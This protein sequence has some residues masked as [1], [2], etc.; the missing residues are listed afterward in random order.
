MNV[1]QVCVKLAGRDA[2]KLAVI[3]EKVDSKMVIIDG[4]VRRRKCNLNHLEPTTKT[5][6]IES[7]ASEADVKRAFEAAGWLYRRDTNRKPASQRPKS[8]RS[9]AVNEAPVETKKQKKEK[10]EAKSDKPKKEVK[11]AEEK[12]AKVKTAKPKK[13]EQ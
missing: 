8:A 12:P 9:M 3:V 11:S 1:G 5:I 10:T 6:D 4:E 7:G 13:A 2:G